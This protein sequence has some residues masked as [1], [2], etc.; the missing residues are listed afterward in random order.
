VFGSPSSSLQKAASP[1]TAS[2][3]AAKSGVDDSVQL[4]ALAEERA[5]RAVC[6]ELEAAAT[7]ANAARAPKL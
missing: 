5:A 4:A 3:A 6:A 2:P 7:A 1:R